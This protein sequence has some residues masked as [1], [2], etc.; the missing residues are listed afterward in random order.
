MKKILMLATLLLASASAAFSQ[1]LVVDAKPACSAPLTG[2]YATYEAASTQDSSSGFGQLNEVPLGFRPC[3]TY[4]TLTVE[5]G[6]PLPTT[7]TGGA[8]FGIY[9]ATTDTVIDCVISTSD[10]SCSA[11]SSITLAMLDNVYFIIYIGGGAGT[12][13]FTATNVVWRLE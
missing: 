7:G 13:G 10:T 8:A 9:D 12:N 5:L 3:G 1:S 6:A 2:T 11:T 4:T